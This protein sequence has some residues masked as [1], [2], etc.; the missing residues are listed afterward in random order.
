VYEKHTTYIATVIAPVVTN[1]W[2]LSK[3]FNYRLVTTNYFLV[4]IKM[5][6]HHTPANY[7]TP[8]TEHHISIST[9]KTRRNVIFATPTRNTPSPAP[10]SRLYSLSIPRVVPHSHFRPVVPPKS[11]LVRQ[12]SFINDLHFPSSDERN[13]NNL[14]KDY[15]QYLLRALV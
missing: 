15:I 4:H 11:N 7:L 1:Y 13:E 8:I 10:Q 5:Y 6:L 12:R 14:G 3:A 9:P 2:C